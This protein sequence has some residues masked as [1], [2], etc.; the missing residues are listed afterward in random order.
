MN[1]ADVPGTFQHRQVATN[2]FRRNR[3]FLGQRGDVDAPIGSGAQQDLL[4][5]FF[6][7][8]RNPPS[9]TS[10]VYPFVSVYL[11]LSLFRCQGEIEGAEWLGASWWARKTPPGRCGV[12]GGARGGAKDSTGGLGRGSGVARGV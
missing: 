6:S 11:C 8:H 10:P 3:Q 7:K 4:V 9:A 5:S 1:P 2:R 12:V